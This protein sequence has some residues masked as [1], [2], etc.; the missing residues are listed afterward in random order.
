[1]HGNLKFDVP[2]CDLLLI[3]GD[4]CPAEYDPFTSSYMQKDWLE[5]K[6]NPWLSEQ[7]IKQS[8]MIAGNHDW[9]WETHP[10]L[11]PWMHFSCC[12]VE[13]DYAITTSLDPPLK[14]YGTPVQPPF[15]DWAFNRGEEQIQKYWDN[16][17]EGLD[18]LLCHC[19]PY[20]ILDATHHPKYTSEHIGSKSLL[21][22]IKEVKPKLV[23]FGHNHGEHGV[24][25][26]D[27]IKYV[28]A[29]LVDEEYKMT[30]KPIVIEM[31]L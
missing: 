11:V 9:I 18:I 17:P 2:E 16:I 24:V 1:M 13:D 4:L 7:P 8:V 23:V 6:F 25:E 20:G 30:R 15:C 12:Y 3:A 21:K 27:G 22:R 5:K 29:S 19:P 31:E 10:H 26:E 28:N 14:I